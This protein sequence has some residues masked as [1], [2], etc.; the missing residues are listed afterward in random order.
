MRRVVLSTT[1]VGFPS[2]VPE[3]TSVHWHGILLPANMD[4]VPGLSFDGIPPGETFVYRFQL[5]QSGSYW[6]HSHSL[7]QE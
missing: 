6:Y 3:P 5:R 7:F 4:G 1:G 2:S